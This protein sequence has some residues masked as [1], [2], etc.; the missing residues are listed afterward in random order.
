[1][2]SI[3][4][5]G[6]VWLF[7]GEYSIMLKVGVYTKTL[8][9]CMLMYFAIEIENDEYLTLRWGMEAKAQMKMFS[10]HLSQ[11]LTRKLNVSEMVSERLRLDPRMKRSINTLDWDEA[12]KLKQ[13]KN[14]QWTPQSGVDTK[15]KCEWNGQWAP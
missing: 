10:E 11:V 2:Q 12:W 6:I 3:W 13:N 15:T 1:M 9:D 8:D 5:W 4:Y 7:C 14:A